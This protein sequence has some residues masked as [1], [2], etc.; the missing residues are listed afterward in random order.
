MHGANRL[1]GNSLSD[2]LVFGRR[3]G[4]GAAEFAKRQQFS[5]PLESELQRS[6]GEALSPFDRSS[7]ENPYQVQADLQK[8]MQGDAGIVRDKSG[9]EAAIA[10]IEKLKHRAARLGV[11]GSREYNPGWHTANDLKS[12]LIVSEAVAKAGLARTESRGAHTRV[13]YPDSDKKQERIQYVIRKEGDRMLLRPEQQPDLP[14]DLAQIIKDG[15]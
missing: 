15:A 6:I 9:L 10:G 2:L 1:G 5:A 4:A 11:V 14:P 3:A 12:L 13:D 7:G 8:V